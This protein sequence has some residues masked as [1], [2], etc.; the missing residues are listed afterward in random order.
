MKTMIPFIK[1]ERKILSSLQIH[2]IAFL[3]LAATGGFNAIAGG[4]YLK[5][6]YPVST[7]TNE[8]QVAVTYTLWIPDGAKT[9]RGIIVHQHGAGVDTSKEESAAAYDLH[10]QALAKKWDCALLGPRYHVLT[11]NNSIGSRM[12]TFKFDSLTGKQVLI[13]T[14][15]IGSGNPNAMKLLMSVQTGDLPTGFLQEA[16]FGNRGTNYGWGI[17]TCILR[18]PHPGVGAMLPPGTFGHGGSWGTQAWIDP[19]RGVAYVLMVQR[20]DSGNADASEIRRVFQQTAADA[21]AR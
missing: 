8:L 12:F 6:D 20:P 9:I 14:N 13:E 7:N 17:G 16:E 21:L 3:M 5:V 10:W 15:G 19:V 2:F 4:T 1:L 11:E 18:I